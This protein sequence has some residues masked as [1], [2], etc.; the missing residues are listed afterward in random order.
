MYM[1]QAI[2][3]VVGPFTNYLDVCAVNMTKDANKIK[4]NAEITI[5]RTEKNH[6]DLKQN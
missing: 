6:F 2:S 3:K 4:H 1:Y 5:Q